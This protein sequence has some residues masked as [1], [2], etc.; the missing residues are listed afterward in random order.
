MAGSHCRRQRV[1]LR[2]RLRQRRRPW[3]CVR[4][5]RVEVVEES[6]DTGDCGTCDGIVDLGVGDLGGT[7]GG[8]MDFVR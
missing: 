2:L 4:F 5:V 7:P 6:G 1:P 8:V 3:G